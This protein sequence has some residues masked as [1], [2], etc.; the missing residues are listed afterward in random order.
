DADGFTAGQVLA[1]RPPGFDQ[2]AR[3]RLG[4]DGNRAYPAHQPPQCPP[5]RVR[6]PRNE[7]ESPLLRQ[8]DKQTVDETDVITD[9]QNRSPGRHIFQS[10]HPYAE[11]QKTR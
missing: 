10:T 3:P 4:I 7:M 2:S 8:E 9:D 1:C 11:E 5:T 6:G